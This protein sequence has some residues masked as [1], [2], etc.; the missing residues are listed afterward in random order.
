MSMDVNLKVGPARTS[1]LSGRS[2]GAQRW[3][4]FPLVAGAVALSGSESGRASPAAKTDKVADQPQLALDD[5]TQERLLEA[6]AE[7]KARLESMRDQLAAA[8]AA[9]E[10]LELLDDQIAVVEAAEEAVQ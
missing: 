9:A 2:V 10:N 5:E 1:L 8:G 3:L 7:A 6:H 4:L